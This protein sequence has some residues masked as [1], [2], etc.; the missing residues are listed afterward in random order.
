M[1][2]NLPRF[3]PS[4]VE[5][6]T[7]A[8]DSRPQLISEMPFE[9]YLSNSI[10]SLRQECRRACNKGIKGSEVEDVEFV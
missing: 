6:E 10:P 7:L 9:M 5:L 4:R 3:L 1:R 8:A 2:H